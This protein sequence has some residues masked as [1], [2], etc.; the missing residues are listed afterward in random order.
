MSAGLQDMASERKNV[1]AEE[2][3]LQGDVVDEELL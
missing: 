3:A 2:S 1:W